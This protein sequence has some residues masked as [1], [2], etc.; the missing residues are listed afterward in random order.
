[1]WPWPSRRCAPQGRKPGEPRAGSGVPSACP[2]SCSN[3]R[4]ANL[5]TLGGVTR[6][7][8][9][10]P[11]QDL[12]SHVTS[13]TLRDRIPPPQI[14]DSRSMLGPLVRGGASF[15]GDDRSQRFL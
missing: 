7:S 13:L 11:F 3:S 8:Q 9:L 14:I 10:F 12:T 6:V 4:V 5:L 2:P 1:M 15:E